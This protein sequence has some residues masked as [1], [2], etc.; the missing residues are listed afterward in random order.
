MYGPVPAGGMFTFDGGVLF[1][2]M[3]ANGT[4]S[5]SRNSGSASVRLNVTL[6]PSTLMPVRSHVFGVFRQASAPSMTLY[7]EPAFGLSPILKMRLNVALTS[8]P[9][10]GV[11][12]ENLIPLR[13]VNVHVLPPLVGLG[14]DSARSATIFVPSLPLARLKPTRPSCVMIRNCHSCSV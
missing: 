1:G 11:P 6:F 7:Q 10:S 2:R 9:V 14:T 13:S 3:N 5:L 8:S 4:A 12:S